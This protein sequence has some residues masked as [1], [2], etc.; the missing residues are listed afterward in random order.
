MRYRISL[1]PQHEFFA[2]RFALTGAIS[3]GEGGIK[4]GLLAIPDR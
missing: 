2:C 1:I 4:N 3:V